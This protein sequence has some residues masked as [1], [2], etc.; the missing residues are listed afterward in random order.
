M[1]IEKSDF[2]IL[3]S[4]YTYK[5]LPKHREKLVINGEFK[6]G[7]KQEPLGETELNLISIPGVD[8]IEAL[9]FDCRQRPIVYGPDAYANKIK[10]QAWISDN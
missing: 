5:Q 6:N 1:N 8:E 10:L 9:L 3:S 7:A 4:Q 2:Y